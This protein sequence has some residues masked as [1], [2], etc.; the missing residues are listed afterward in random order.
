[1]AKFTHLQ[2]ICALEAI[3]H[4]KSIS[5]VAR[6]LGVSRQ[7]LHK[8]M[9]QQGYPEVSL[10]QIINSLERQVAQE[11]ALDDYIERKKAIRSN[12][13]LPK[14]D[15]K[16]RNY[17]E[18]RIASQV[19]MLGVLEKTTHSLSC[20]FPGDQRVKHFIQELKELRCQTN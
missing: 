10:V 19:L 6:G 11:V 9:K 5:A 2:F 16:F 1:M 4:G 15:I 14:G 17:D 3:L 18:F 7:T 8:R 12:V 20:M 13:K